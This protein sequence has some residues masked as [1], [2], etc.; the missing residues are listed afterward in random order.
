MPPLGSAARADQLGTLRAAAPR[1]ARRRR[2]RRLPR[3]ARAARRGRRGG[4]EDPPPSA[5]PEVAADRDRA[6][7][8]VTRRDR[9][10]AL[11]VPSSLLAELA[12]AGSRGKHAWATA[13]AANDFAAVPAAPARDRRRCA[14]ATSSASRTSSTPTTR[15]STTTSRACAPPRCGR[16]SRSCARGCVP[17]VAAIARGAR[18]RAADPSRCAGPFPIDAQRRLVA[19]ACWTRSASTRSATASMSPPTRSATDD[20]AR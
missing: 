15:C 7:V 5:E 18:G 6:L 10:K 11:R 9:E 12:R 4:A 13:R 8:R 14:A 2:A 16:S 20:L 3:G 1:P 17:L 19:L